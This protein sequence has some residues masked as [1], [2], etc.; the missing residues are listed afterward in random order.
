V[1]HGGPEAATP[2]EQRTL[3]IDLLTTFQ[4]QAGELIDKEFQTWVAQ[5]QE[6]LAALQATIDKDKKERSSGN[7]VITY[8]AP[9]T[10]T[11]SADI[12][13]N[14]QLVR[15]TDSG[16][17]LLPALTPDTYLVQ[18]KANN[19][20]LQGSKTVKVESGQTSEVS[21]ELKTVTPGT[22]IP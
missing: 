18:V 21:I 20:A 5:F 16:G 11:G 13:L 22:T 1:A 10:I 19:G 9:A 6:Q 3:A 17:M 15:Q 12:Y 7:L 14:N 8:H 2:A 4:Q